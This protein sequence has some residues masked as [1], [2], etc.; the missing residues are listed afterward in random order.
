MSDELKKRFREMED[1]K[2]DQSLYLNVGSVLENY[3]GDVLRGTYNLKKKSITPTEPSIRRQSQRRSSIRRQSQ[4]RSATVEITPLEIS[5]SLSKYDYDDDQPPGERPIYCPPEWNALTKGA[6]TELTTMLSWE[7]LSRWDFD[8]REVARLSK[9]LLRSGSFPDTIDRPACPLLLVGWAILCEPHAQRA[10][11]GSLGDRMTSDD[12][13]DSDKG[14]GNGNDNGNDDDNDNEDGGEKPFPYS[15]DVLNIDPEKVCNF[16][17][18]IEKRY[19]HDVPYHNNVHAADVTQTLHC[20]LQFLGKDL[21]QSIYDP[22]EVF[23]MLLAATFHDVAHPGTNNLFQKHSCSKH[24]M[25]Y[26]D[27]SILENMHCAVG[28]SYLMGEDRKKEWDIFKEWNEEM[29]VRA[30]EVMVE[31]ILSTDMSHHFEHVGE[32]TSLAEKVGTDAGKDESAPKPI[33]RILSDALD[34]LKKGEEVPSKKACLKLKDFLLKFLLHCADI[35]NPAKPRQLCIPWADRALAEFFAQGDE[36]ERRGLPISPMCDRATTA[37]ADSQIGFLKF[38]IRPTYL[39]LGEIVPRVGS[40]LIPIVDGNIAYWSGEKSRLTLAGRASNL[41]VEDMREG[42]QEEGSGDEDDDENVD[43]GD[44]ID[45]LTPSCPS[46]NG[47]SAA[48]GE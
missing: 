8:V 1:H 4:R 46:E 15:F 19:V 20:L 35:S 7:R 37:R 12:D 6:R 23:S 29:K 9:E 45:D 26:N 2:T 10:M 33:L 13:D 44:E 38:V 32:L 5:G 31:A 28:H 25:R 43:S 36:E 41:T 34:R 21:L 48:S 24:A 42:I 3:G 30:R 39:V 18:E 27:V 16:L 11:E 40:D 14:D 47:G 17:R 22:L